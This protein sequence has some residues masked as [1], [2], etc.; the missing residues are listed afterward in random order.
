LPTGSCFR[1][2]SD[3]LDLFVRLTPRSSRDAIEGVGQASDGSTHLVA[4]VRALPESGAANAALEKLLSKWLNVPKQSI[5][6]VSG[7][8]ARMKTVR[9]TGEPGILSHAIES[10]LG[11]GSSPKSR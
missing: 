7:S 6:I 10:A 9:L 1:T 5:S 11:L 2:R 3:G 8:T 4:R